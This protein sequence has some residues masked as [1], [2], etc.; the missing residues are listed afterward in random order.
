MACRV[1]IALM[2]NGWPVMRETGVISGL[3]LHILVL[4]AWA[5]REDTND[6]TFNGAGDRNT[7]KYVVFRGHPL[8]RVCNSSSERGNE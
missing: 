8:D 1:E 6:R 2:L 4:D 5:I 7:G 3:D